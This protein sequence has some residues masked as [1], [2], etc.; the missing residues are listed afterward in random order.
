MVLQVLGVLWL[1]KIGANIC[2]IRLKMKRIIFKLL[3]MEEVNFN[4]GDINN[5]I[6][7]EEY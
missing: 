2:G 3:N 7:I 1:Q 4:N 5:Y 6:F